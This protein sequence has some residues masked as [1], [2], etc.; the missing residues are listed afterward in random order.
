M[1]KLKPFLVLSLAALVAACGASA[2][3]F[4]P[5]PE[6]VPVPAGAPGRALS[7][8]IADGQVFAVFSDA[9]STTLKLLRLP[10]SDHLPGTLP[11]AEVI[12]KI[13]GAPPLSPRFGANVMA[14]S[15]SEVG[16]LYL[17]RQAEDKMVLKLA[18]RAPEAAQWTMDIIEPPGEP[19]AILPAGSGALSVFWGA[20]SLMSRD[21]P[22][23]AAAQV[24]AD[25]FTPVD[26]ASVS[27]PAAF[28]AWD[29]ASRS[30]VSVSRNG[31]GYVT[32]AIAGAG[33]VQAS[34]VLPDGRLA[35]LTWEE[36]S[37]RLLLLEEK[38]GGAMERTTVTLC[39]ETST[40]AI[41]P[42]R[43]GYLFLYDEA[44]K[45]AVGGPRH[46]LS[47]LS[48]VGGRYRKT[49]LLSGAGPIEAFAAARTA[50]ALYVVVLQGGIKLVRVAVPPA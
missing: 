8:G 25:S 23:N 22:G 30:L 47:L 41:L 50:D 18:T 49:T 46:A 20:S 14:V 43:S 42:A 38:P 48:R 29:R 5:T 37:Q 15:D 9:A 36:G 16:V 24:L 10:L 39:D 32:R 44:Q 45:G 28:T 2:G 1:V 31:E 26:R 27:G 7:I 33:A 13:D 11:A 34:L 4:A 21:S 40:V 12:D 6:V 35:V 17:A 3:P 19:L